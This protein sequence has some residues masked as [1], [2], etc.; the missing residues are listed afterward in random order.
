MLELDDED[1]GEGV[2]NCQSYLLSFYVFVLRALLLWF[3]FS[4][5][6]LLLLFFLSLSL[7]LL[8]LSSLV[9][10]FFICCSWNRGVGVTG[11]KA[12]D[13]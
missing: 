9:F 11:D 10:S 12:A 8:V 6:G 5:L 13:A 4:L 7:C 1:D 3:C 2:L